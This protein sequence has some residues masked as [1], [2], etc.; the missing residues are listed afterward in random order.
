MGPAP[1]PAESGS[2]TLVSEP[3]SGDTDGDSADEA[4][5]HGAGYSTPAHNTGSPPAKPKCGPARNHLP[6]RVLPPLVRHFFHRP[7]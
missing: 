6:A 3:R 4:L 1:T 2:V 7:T 5:S